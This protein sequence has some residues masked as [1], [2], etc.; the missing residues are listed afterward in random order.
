[1]QV[2]AVQLDIRWEDKDANFARVRELLDSTAPPDGGVIVLPEM[3]ATG[4]TMKPQKTAEPP[5]GPTEEFL[6]S[7][8]K[9]TG[10]LVIAGAVTASGNGQ[11]PAN[12]ALIVSPAGVAVRQSKV[13]PFSLVGE[14]NH[15]RGGREL[16][17]I[18]Y[19]GATLAPLVCYDLRFPEVFRALAVAGAEVFVVIANWP[20]VRAE[21]WRTLLRARA[22]ENH[23]FVV[24]VNRCGEDPNVAYAGGS[25]VFAP[26]GECLAEAD[27]VEQVL[28]RELSLRELARSRV[29][30]CSLRDVRDDLFPA[31]AVTHHA[32]G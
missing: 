26:D 15:H 9:E 28:S 25:V 13:H 7:L 21:H 24:G 27:P 12:D 3:F 11:K 30:F 32:L 2:H 18:G 14:Q 17:T 20:A 19:A 16:F 8:A 23:A 31:P 4:F 10:C 5:G 6:R 22:I 1:V 29:G